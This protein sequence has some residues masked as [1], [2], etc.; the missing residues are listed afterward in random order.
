M[1]LIAF[2]I[3]KRRKYLVLVL[4]RRLYVCDM[5]LEQEGVFGNVQIDELNIN[6]LALDDD[7]LTLDNNYVLNS[8]FM[9]RT[10]FNSFLKLV[11]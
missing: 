8:V 7:L 4:P 1:K 3:D 11:T 5:V 9:V 10:G 2:C 6:F